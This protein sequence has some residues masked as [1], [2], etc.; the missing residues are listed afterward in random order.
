[1]NIDIVPDYM[2]FYRIGS[3]HESMGRICEPVEEETPNKE[4]DHDE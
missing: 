2:V 3:Y 1:M 4:V